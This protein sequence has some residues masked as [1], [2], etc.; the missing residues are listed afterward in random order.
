MQ[1]EVQVITQSLTFLQKNQDLIIGFGL[2]LLVAIFI[3]YIGRWVALGV[4]RLVGKALLLRHV[5]RAVVSFLSSIVYAAVLI[6]FTLMAL[7]QL[8]IQTASFLAIL[9][10]A[11]LAVALALQGSLSNFASG[12]LIIVFRPFKSGD[13]V[14]VA[15]ISGVVERIDIFQT[16]FKTGDNKKIIVPNSQITGG[17]IVNYS[18]EKRRRIDLTISISYDSDLR[19]AKQILHDILQ[20]D[21]RVLKDPEAV[22]AVGALADSSVQLIVRPWVEA[23]DYWA[24]YWDSLEQIKLQFDAAGIEIPYPQMSLHMKPHKDEA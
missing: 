9:G 23:A 11:G 19:L 22:I 14:E 20:A 10:A 4:S 13:L 15:G 12:V 3:F 6:A 17:A 5:D 1:Q 21:S 8:G 7:S 18:A 2:K 24:V 16:I